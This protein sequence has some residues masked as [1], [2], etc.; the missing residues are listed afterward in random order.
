MVETIR[1]D[2]H[3][4]DGE[5]FTNKILDA[6]AGVILNAVANNFE[7]RNVG[8]EGEHPVR[9]NNIVKLAV[10]NRNATG[11]IENFYFGD[12]V[13]E[14]S[15]GGM[16]VHGGHS[17]ELTFRNVNVQGISNN[18]LYATPPGANGNPGLT[19]VENSYFACNNISN[20]R[21]GNKSGTSYVRD[22][23]IHATQA[24]TPECDVNCN[25][26][27]PSSKTPRGVWAW[28][29]RVHVQNC[30]IN[31]EGVPHLVEKAGTGAS[32]TR[33]NTRVGRNA[34]NFVPDGVPRSAREAASGGGGRSLDDIIKDGENEIAVVRR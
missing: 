25:D 16:Y 10:P 21:V 20:V 28:Y 11:L 31:V 6:S 15:K 13:D 33:Q 18:G 17:G 29:G 3:L 30:D 2:V 12:G 34:R 23:V 32:I 27:N 26:P 19:H 9:H 5:K 8:F 14:G 4:S 24:C 7:I 22:T 1:S